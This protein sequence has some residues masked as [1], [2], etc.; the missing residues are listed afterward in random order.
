MPESVNL[1][2]QIHKLNEIGISLSA[3]KDSS[4]L[5]E[6]ILMHAKNICNADGGTFYLVEG[7]QLRFS[8]LL[9][10]TLN[11]YMGGT[12][13]TPVTIPP[14]KTHY[15]DGTPR[16]DAVAVYTAIMGVHVVIDDIYQAEGFDFTGAKNFDKAQ[17]YRT[18]SL[19]TIPLK[20]H[21]DAVI[22][23]I[24]LINARDAN[25]MV[26]GFNEMQVQ[27]TRSLASQASVAL[28]N[29]F[30]IDEH[31]S[32]FESVAKMIA[33]TI[34]KKSPYTGAHCKRVPIIAVM[35]AKAASQEKEGPLADFKM[36]EN[37]Y[38]ELET[39]AWLHDCG[40]LVT[41]E[42]VMDKAK[43]LQTIFDRVEL[44][45]TRMAALK[46]QWQL[47]PEQY[48]FDLQQIDQ[49]MEFIRQMNTG[50]EFL[51]DEKLAEL[52]KIRHVQW[53][54]FAGER[55]N[56]ISDDEFYNL[57]IRK[58]TLTAEERQIIQDHAQATIDMLAELPFPRDL[59]NVPEY[60]GCHHET[61]DGKGYPRHLTREQMSIPARIMAIADIFEALSAGDRPYKDGKT[62]SEV[63]K[64]MGFMV[65]DGHIDP[66][67][68]NVM[69]DQK[70]Y[71]TYAKV[72]MKPAQIDEVDESKIPNYVPRHLRLG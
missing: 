11:T 20:N 32:L 25:G 49:W 54:N 21:E 15:E 71:L 69:I 6:K 10:D 56:L 45:Q 18:Q 13:G 22:G 1:F 12:S 37:D 61:M 42:S 67:V 26:V 70:V 41:P 33:Y 59:S 23:V 60:A 58:G 19:L 2:E 66:D 3:E 14:L 28:T 64:I 72:H 53:I 27:L 46:S 4:S 35:L 51:S 5:V 48:D 7:N 68:F 57:S 30:L 38:F 52:E 47:D 16:L 29:K 40:K 36:Q 55:E 50:G 17:N 65:K 39:A 63:L 31:R 34:D 9:N 44:I 43:K 24:Q 62:L 8:I